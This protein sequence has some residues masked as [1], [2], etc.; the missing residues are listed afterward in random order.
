M[1]IV[2]IPMIAVG[3]DKK[4]IDKEDMDP[5]PIVAIDTNFD[6]L[7]SFSRELNV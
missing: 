5:I 7:Q 3:I 4:I 2:I 6:H 1:I